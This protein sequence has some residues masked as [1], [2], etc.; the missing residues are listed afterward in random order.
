M[1]NSADTEQR[2]RALAQSLDCYTV[3]DI[4]D[5]YG[6]TPGTAEAWRKRGK[7][8]THIQAANRPLYPKANVSQDLN[9][10]VRERRHHTAKDAL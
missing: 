1:N 3:E 9:A 5:L 2:V 4:C 6:I 7:G 8:P 10:R